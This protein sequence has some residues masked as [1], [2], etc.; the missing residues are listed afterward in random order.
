MH[1]IDH[2][3]RWSRNCCF[4][5]QQFLAGLGHRHGER[6]AE[7]VLLQQS[8]FQLDA[9]QSGGLQVQQVVVVPEPAKPEGDHQRHGQVGRHAAAR[10]SSTNGLSQP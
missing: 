4:A 2:R 9:L 6:R 7:I 10:A 3:A 1:R 8:L 5:G